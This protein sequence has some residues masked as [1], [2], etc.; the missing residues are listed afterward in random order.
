M[1]TLTLYQTIIKKEKNRKKKVSMVI[2]RYSNI[3]KK[4][5]SK[6]SI[7]IKREFPFW[8]TYIEIE[9]EKK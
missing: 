9:E 3:P 1:Y 7:Q 6:K 4:E 5:I 8:N 2:K